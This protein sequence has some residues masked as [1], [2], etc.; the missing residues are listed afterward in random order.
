MHWVVAIVLL[1]GS[2]VV[3]AWSNWGRLGRTVACNVRRQR[4]CWKGGAVSGL[5]HQH[6]PCISSSNAR[7]F[8]HPVAPSATATGDCSSGTTIYDDQLQ[9]SNGVSMQ[10]LCSFPEESNKNNTTN[11]MI[12][13]ESSSPPPL[14]FLHGS[15]H[16]AWCWSEHYFS[17]FTDRGYTVVAAS[18]RGTGGTPVI[19]TA[20]KK[21]P[22]QCHVQDL[23]ALLQALPSFLH[24]KQRKSHSLSSHSNNVA[25]NP[26]VICHSFAGIAVM[27]YLEVYAADSTVAQQQQQQNNAPFS[28]I[29]TMCSVPPSGNGKMTLRFL[30]RSLQASWRITRGL[31]MKQCL[32][33]A[34]LCRQLFFGGG[35]PNRHSDGTSE[36]DGDDHGI[37]DETIARY[38][39]YFRRDSAA[40]IN[41]MDLAK[42]LPSAQANAFNGEAHFVQQQKEN[43]PPCLILGA[44]SDYIVDLEGVQETARYFGVDPSDV[45]M[46]DSP[47]D[48][49]L[50]AKWVNG[51]E[52]LDQWL[53]AMSKMN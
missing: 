49:M 35:G 52:A 13:S 7:F 18:W 53:S 32:T 8:R 2:P 39:D 41:L 38:Q 30:R 37:S 45:V 4:C 11:W 14:L 33:D 44:S 19:D 16:G 46:V 48:T 9:L 26:V 6:H 23:G 40:T 5:P 12:Q 43:L 29:V 21:V 28:A 24:E 25:L 17:Y 34:K 15:F 27:K 20:M 3:T 47:H 1:F 51:A 10:V 31:A 42:K 36:D 50:G 22:I